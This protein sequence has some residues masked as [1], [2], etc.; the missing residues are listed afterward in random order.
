[1]IESIQP[2]PGKLDFP[3]L[4]DKD[5]KVVDNYGILNP[6]EAKPGIP[7]PTTYIINKAG[8]VAHR[9]IDPVHYSRANE[10]QIRE[11]LKKIGAVQ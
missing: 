9:F 2:W 6:I 3:L 11:E 5:H 7:Y 4:E 8:L 10:E 1:M